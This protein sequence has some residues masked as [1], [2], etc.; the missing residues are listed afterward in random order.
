MVQTSSFLKNPLNQTQ[1]YIILHQW[2]EKGQKNI[3]LEKN[4]T[5]FITKILLRLKMPFFLKMCI[6]GKFCRGFPLKLKNCITPIFVIKMSWNLVDLLI[7]L[8]RFWI[9]SR[10]F[11]C[12]FLNGPNF[13]RL[14]LPFS[15]VWMKCLFKLLCLSNLAA[16][17]GSFCRIFGYPAEEESKSISGMS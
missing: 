2:I 13:V 17:F 16:K 10:I 12:F 9:W 5:F 1:F 7:N 8:S 15:A 4:K 6:F 3:I 11:C 14:F